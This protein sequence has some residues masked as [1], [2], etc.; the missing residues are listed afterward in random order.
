MKLDNFYLNLEKINTIEKLEERNRIHE[1]YREMLYAESDNRTKI[2]ES[3][4]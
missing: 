1:M 2:S 4:F 3:F